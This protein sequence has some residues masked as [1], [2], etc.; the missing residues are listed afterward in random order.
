MKILSQYVLQE[1]CKIFSL[2]LCGSLAVIIVFDFF[3]NLDL[4]TLFQAPPKLFFSFL[5]FRIPSMIY[6][7]IP[8]AALIATLICLTLFARNREIMA[9]RANGISFYNLAAPIL[10]TCLGLSLVCLIFNESIVPAANA[11][12]RQIERIDIKKKAPIYAFPM[13]YIW[14]RNLNNIYSIQWYDEKTGTIHQVSINE[15]DKRFELVNRWEAR[16]G[17]WDGQNWVFHDLNIKQLD[18]EGRFQLTKMDTAPIPF[19]LKPEDF[20][21]PEKKAEEMS[22]FELRDYIQQAQREG[23]DVTSYL[24]GLHAKLAFPFICFIMP[25]IAVPLALR[26][27]SGT[28]IATGMGMGLL[29]GFGYWMIFGFSLSLAR[30][31][32]LPPLIAAWLTNLLFASF[33]VF[34]LL[35]VRQ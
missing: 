23:Y 32:F 4:I 28:G 18:R 14:F 19:P 13:K 10:A 29:L 6:Q 35:R 27:G 21:R 16:I 25:L 34:L 12:S 31:G 26:T 20:T 17:T 33:G 2:T 5:L 22:Y 9:M 24:T 7:L 11:R 3:E 8:L 15:F 30:G 1:F